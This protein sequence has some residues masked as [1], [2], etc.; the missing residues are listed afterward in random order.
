MAN[1]RNE[2]NARYKE[3]VLTKFMAYAEQIAGEGWVK[4][5]KSNTFGFYFVNDNGDE[6]TLTVTISVPNGSRDGD[7]YDLDGEADAYESN[8]KMKK[9]KA[10]KAAAEKQKKIEADKK[11]REASKKR[12]QA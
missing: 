9:E 7:P 1:K 4:R 5:T 6:E 11:R 3:E 12:T 2:S 10:E 8:L